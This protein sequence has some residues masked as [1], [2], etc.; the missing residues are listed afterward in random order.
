M[1]KER[2][3]DLTDD[4]GKGSC[5]KKGGRGP[6]PQKKKPIVS[7]GKEKSSKPPGEEKKGGKA[8]GLKN[9]RSENKGDGHRKGENGIARPRKDQGRKIIHPE[10]GGIK[11]WQGEHQRH[12]Q[13][14]T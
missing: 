11:P 4:P 9:N 12:L 7:N 8:N 13:R 14:G 5:E 10:K 3:I 1:P 2:W 6:K